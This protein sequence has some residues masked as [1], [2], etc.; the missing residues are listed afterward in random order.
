MLTSDID[1]HPPANKDKENPESNSTN[2]KQPI[3]ESKKQE[4]KINEVKSVTNLKLNKSEIHV[5]TL[6][7]TTLKSEE[8]LTELIYALKQ[9]K[10]D[11]LGLSEVRRSGERIVAHP[12]YILCYKGETPGSYGVGFIIKKHLASHIESFVGISERI[13]VLNI[14]L[15]G[16]RDL[17]SI[18]Q[19][20]S[21]TEQAEEETISTFYHDLNKTID[22]YAHKNF[23]VGNGRFQCSNWSLEA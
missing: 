3:S 19:V 8:K 16:H 5:T 23:I 20:Y 10:W 18:I 7:V 9:I 15:P 17:W 6:N 4:P 11:I 2:S 12:D 1:R 21:P 14:K 22:S 13:A